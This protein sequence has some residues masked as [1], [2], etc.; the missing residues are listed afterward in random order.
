MGFA[1]DLMR[2]SS[3]DSD[4]VDARAAVRALATV[5]S[6]GGGS[7]AEVKVGRNGE[8]VAGRWTRE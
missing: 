1:V 4:L 5:T 8:Q 3:F 7:I 2:R 6:N